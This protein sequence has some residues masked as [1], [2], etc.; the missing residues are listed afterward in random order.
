MKKITQVF[1]VLAFT[2]GSAMNLLS[3]ATASGVIQGT[4]LDNSQAVI[5]GAEITATNTGTGA[6]RVVTTSATGDYRF[7]LLPAGKYSIQI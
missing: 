4:V 3:Q 2:L 7:D 6:K 1:L 5:V